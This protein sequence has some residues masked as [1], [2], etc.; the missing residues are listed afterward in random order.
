MTIG[1]TIQVPPFWLSPAGY[2]INEIASVCG[3]SIDTAN[4]HSGREIGRIAYTRPGGSSPPLEESRENFSIAIPYLGSE[5]ASPAEQGDWGARSCFWGDDGVPLHVRS[6]VIALNSGVP[7]ARWA[8]GGEP[9]IVMREA[10]GKAFVEFS[11]DAIS[12]YFLAITQ[13]DEDAIQE[14]DVHGR[15]PQSMTFPVVNGMTHSPVATDSALLVGKAAQEVCQ[16][17]RSFLL[18]KTPWPFG[19]HA[20]ACIT[21]DVDSVRKW[22]IPRIVGHTRGH[23]RAE[24]RQAGPP[25]RSTILNTIAEMSGLLDPHRNLGEISALETS[26][27]VRS[28]FFVQMARRGS[29]RDPL[30]MYGYRNPY[31]RREMKQ[32]SWQ[33]HELA[34]HS[35]YESADEPA[36]LSEEV[37]RISIL[38]R[39]T[40][41]RQHYLRIHRRVW[42]EQESIGL[43]YDSSVGYSEFV[44]FRSGACHPYHPFDSQEARRFSVLEIPFQVMDSALYDSCHGRRGEM[45]GLLSLLAED[46]SYRNGVLV[47]IWHNH[48]LDGALVKPGS[49]LEWYL[50]FLKGRGWHF[51]TMGQVARWWKARDGADLVS[52]DPDTWT[53]FPREN[54]E[55]LA[56]RS[57]GGVPAR[58]EGLAEGEWSVVQEGRFRILLLRGLRASHP[59]T[60]HRGAAI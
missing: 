10:G 47:S 36:R 1:V 58:V 2:V 7:L 51:W 44:G 31:V 12:S 53:L 24:S 16:R 39:A 30:A 45:E 40:G 50:E 23:A 25:M 29:R 28:T 20:V 4:H 11:F 9:A 5:T 56:I 43:L 22:I 55:Q 42:R 37:N 26:R 60:I 13:R 3:L 46:V 48:F 17:T 35:T 27:G 18:T 41:A 8:D 49:I 15:P 38:S 33:G 59:V 6:P 57:D 54:M 14:R 52:R 32:A 34:L 21:H 19:I